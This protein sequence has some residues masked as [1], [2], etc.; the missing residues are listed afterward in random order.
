MLKL[1]K[2]MRLR[3]WLMMIGLLA[4]LVLQLFCDVTLPTYTSEIVAKMQAGAEAGSILHTGLIMLGIAGASVFATV[5]CSVLSA[6]VSTS[7]GKRIRGEVFSH[8]VYLS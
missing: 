3:D 5:I 7:L 1:L 6:I 2:Y 4:F 8:A